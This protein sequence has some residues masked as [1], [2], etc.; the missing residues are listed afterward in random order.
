MRQNW[1]RERILLLFGAGALGAGLFFPWLIG[2]TTTGQVNRLGYEA[3]LGLFAA[4]LGLMVAVLAILRWPPDRKRSLAFVILGFLALL[5][6][7]LEVEVFRVMVTEVESGGHHEAVF[8]QISAGSGYYISLAGGMLVLIGGV[9][10][11][12]TYR[13]PEA[14][15]D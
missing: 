10:S 5:A 15:S 11:L 9:L 12:S 2:T 1:S 6:V 4:A 14:A 8:E 7:W 3:T 13:P